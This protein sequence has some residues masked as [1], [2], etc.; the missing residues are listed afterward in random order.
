M[1]SQKSVALFIETSNAYARGLLEGVLQFVRHHEPWS[2]YLPEQGRGAPP[3][4]W[5]KHWRGDG[6]IARIESKAIA[7]GLEIANLPIVD[8]SAARHSP[9]IPFV[10]TNDKAIARL[11]AEHLIERGFRHL[12]FCGDPGFAWSNY[13][14]EHFAQIASEAGCD[15]HVYESMSRWDEKYSWT[16]E[17][18]QLSKWVRD[19]PRPIGVL[20]CYDIKAQQLLDVCRELNVA[21]PEEMAVLGVDNDLLVCELASPPLSSVIPNTHRTGYEA[22][23]IL[24]RMMSGE[25]VAAEGCFVDPLG[26]QV[27]QSTDILAITDPDVAKA[28]RYIRE[29]AW[30]GITVSDVLREVPLSRRVLESRFRKLLGRTPHE[31]IMHR[32][33]RLVKQLLGETDLSLAEIAKRVGFDNSEYLSV[34]FKREVG[35][36]PSVYRKAV[37]LPA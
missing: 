11:A 21:V 18:R 32:R 2:L 25:K 28:L 6:I 34:A 22:A 16:E 14:K 20:G 30:T 29:N 5:L 4:D 12:G 33:I 37:C 31:E 13:R 26:V 19:L 24:A 1:A 23:A 36:A 35:K 7:K 10:E 17:R 9:T 27:R 3:P 15:L 8:V